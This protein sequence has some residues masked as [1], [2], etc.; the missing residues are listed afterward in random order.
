[1]KEWR[2]MIDY[3]QFVCFDFVDIGAKFLLV[4]CAQK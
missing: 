2:E 4:L 1:M 3:L